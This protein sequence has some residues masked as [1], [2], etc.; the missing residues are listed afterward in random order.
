MPFLLHLGFAV[1]TA[2]FLSLFFAL[3]WEEVAKSLHVKGFGRGNGVRCRFGRNELD[4][5]NYF[6]LASAWVELTRSAMWW[7]I[8]IG[9]ASI[10]LYV[11]FLLVARS[12]GTDQSSAKCGHSRAAAH[13]K[14]GPSQKEHFLERPG[15]SSQAQQSAFTDEPSLPVQCPHRNPTLAFH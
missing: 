12:A 13:S 2:F 4:S 9:H 5:P 11:R 3:H 7:S 15:S 1:I 10:L 14:R 6:R 8:L